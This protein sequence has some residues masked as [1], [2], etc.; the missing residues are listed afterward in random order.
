MALVLRR[1][2]YQGLT[3]TSQPV[4]GLEIMVLCNENAKAVREA[5]TTP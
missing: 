2:S 3:P 5:V 4:P 1:V